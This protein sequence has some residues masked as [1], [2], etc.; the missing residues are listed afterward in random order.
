MYINR[1]MSSRE[2]KI[3]SA[4]KLLATLLFLQSLFFQ[5]D[6]PQLVLCFGPDGH[7]ALERTSNPANCH[8]ND[9]V[10]ETAALLTVPEFGHDQCDDVSLDWHFSRAAKNVL[11]K[12]YIAQINNAVL[13]YP[14]S[15]LSEVRL[16]VS[17]TNL[18]KTNP[19]LETLLKS[20]VLII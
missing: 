7:I 12:S 16:N 1:L 8:E 9:S 19:R 2:K 11:K 4:A 10:S 13:T 3:K 6:L 14:Y 18:Y 15:N 20:T 5:V 17:A